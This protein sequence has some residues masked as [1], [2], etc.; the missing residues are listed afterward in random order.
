M[1]YLG[2]SKKMSQIQA[3]QVQCLVIL[4]GYPFNEQFTVYR[5]HHP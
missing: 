1:L 3:R 2:E 4:D 5:T